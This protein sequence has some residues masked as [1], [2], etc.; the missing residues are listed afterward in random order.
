[1]CT[2]CGFPARPGLWTEAGLEGPGDRLRARFLR[3][4]ILQRVLRPHGLTAHDDGQTAGIQIGTLSG[5]RQIV[6]TVPEIWPAVE[7]LLGRPFDP[8]D[9]DPRDEG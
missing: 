3:A 7:A 4:Q 5:A 2:A 1:M 6:D 9:P 8:L